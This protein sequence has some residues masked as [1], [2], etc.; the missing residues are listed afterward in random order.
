MG[1]AE[2]RWARAGRAGSAALL[3][4]A[5]LVAQGQTKGQAKEPARDL[6]F[7]RAAHLRRGINLS[8]WYAQDRDLYNATGGAEKLASYI[9]ATDFKL[10][11]ELGFDHVRLSIDPEPLIANKATGELRPEAM[12]RLDETVKQITATGLV[13]VL[14]IHP[15]TP[16]KHASTLT[17]EGTAQFFAFWKSFAGHYAATDPE[18]VYFEV[19]NEPEGVDLYRWAGEQA[20]AVAVIRSQAPRHTII[21]GGANWNGIDGLQ[22]LEPLQDNDIVYTFHD[23]D[24]MTFTHQ[25][26]TWAG[27]SLKPL[28]GVPYPS[29]PEN[30]APLVAELPE[31]AAKKDLAWYGH[32]QWN[33]A[34]MEKEIGV[35]VDW[36]RKRHV[37]LWC[38][39]FGVFMEHSEAGDRD[40]WIADMRQTLEKDGVGWSM[41]DYRGGFALVSRKDG[42]PVVDDGAAKALGLKVKP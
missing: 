6:A 37:P 40:R 26:A 34:T 27:E 7:A 13:V 42:V 18:R 12:A 30:V 8:M 5:A 33:I 4:L 28:H 19:M 14:D 2:V 35:A 17:D 16:W 3:L 25:G 10:V 15:E 22:A 11:R 32:Q 20:K 24:P 31:G 38:G 39:E 36:A 41:W 23:Y 1:M 9:N 29:T 21:V